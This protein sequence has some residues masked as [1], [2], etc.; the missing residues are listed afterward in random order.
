MKRNTSRRQILQGLITSSLVVGF[1][2]ISRSWVTFANTADS[3]VNLPYLD[4][5][6]YTD[7]ATR[8][9]AADDFGHLINRYPKAV[10]KPGSVD[11]IVKIIKFARTHRLKVAARGLSSYL[12]RSGTSREWCGH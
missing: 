2:T 5:V 9:S 11:D 7:D 12:L 6:L 4:G 1:D 10:L 3:F 8:A